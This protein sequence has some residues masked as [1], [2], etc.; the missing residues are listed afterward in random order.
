M[1]RKALPKQSSP[2]DLIPSPDHKSHYLTDDNLLLVLVE[3]VLGDFLLI[4]SHALTLHE[5]ATGQ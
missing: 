2:P 3:G 4:S 1:K 5:K